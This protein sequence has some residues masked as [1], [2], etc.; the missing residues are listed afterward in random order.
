LMVC[1]TGSSPINTLGEY[2][3]EHRISIGVGG[4]ICGRQTQVIHR[5]RRTPHRQ[6]A[7]A[8][9]TPS[10]RVGCR[11]V[12]TSGDRIG[13][14]REHRCLGQGRSR[15]IRFEV[16]GEAD[17]LGVIAPEAVALPCRQAIRALSVDVVFRHL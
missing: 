13:A 7:M 14:G 10:L 3:S 1:A 15:A 8:W 17:A 11:E 4:I 16:A 5:Q 12:E 9:K 2:I 6:G